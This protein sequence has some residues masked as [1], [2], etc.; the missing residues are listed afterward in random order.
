MKGS[1]P[2][3]PAWPK[4]TRVIESQL[5]PTDPMSKLPPVIETPEHIA[6]SF[7]VPKRGHA[8]QPAETNENS[9]EP[10]LI[11][12]FLT[13]PLRDPMQGLSPP[14]RARERVTSPSEMEISVTSPSRLPMAGAPLILTS[15]PFT[16]MSET[17]PLTDPTPGMPPPRRRPYPHPSE[18]RRQRRRYL[19]RYHQRRLLPEYTWCYQCRTC[20]S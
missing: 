7:D 4:V 3:S 15:P 19:R 12:I 14:P 16:E 20:R 2:P 1:V 5:C 18:R 8:P 17:S 11:T 13:S 6:L 10:P 9:T